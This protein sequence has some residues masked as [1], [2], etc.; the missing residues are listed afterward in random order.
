M[1]AVGNRA[2]EPPRLHLARRRRLSTRSCVARPLRSWLGIAA[3]VGAPL[4]LIGAL[5]WPLLFTDKVFNPD[6]DNHLW[7]MWHQSQAIRANGFPSLYLNYSGAIFYPYYAFYGGTLYAVAG[8]LSLLLGNAPLETYVLSYLL[9]FAAAYGG[10]YWMAHMFGLRGWLVHVPGVIFV[11]SAPYL[12]TIYGF[13]DWPEFLAVSVI[14]LMIAS[15]LSVLRSPQRRIWP[16]VALVG[17]SIMLYGSHAITAIW[18]TTIMLLGVLAMIVCIRDVRHSMTRT[19]VTRVLALIVPALLVNAWFILPA[20]AYESQTVAAASYPHFR[21]LL[22]SSTYVVAAGHLFTLSIAKVP[23]TFVTVALPVLAIVW[24]IGG[25]AALLLMRRGGAWMQALL[26]VAGATALL[27]VL[28]THASLILALPRVYAILQYSL[29][30]DTFVVMGVVGALMIV[31]VLAGQGG[32]NMPRWCWLL[33]PIAILSVVGALRQIDGY[34]NAKN[35]SVALAS[36]LS[37]VY[38]QEG[39]LAYVDDKLPILQTPLAEVDFPSAKV[40][41]NDVAALVHQPPG[42][43]V[44]TNLRAMP[45]LIHISGARIVGTDSQANDVLEIIARPGA[46]T[47]SSVHGPHSSTAGVRIVAGP[48]RNLPVVIGHWLTIFALVFLAAELGLIAVRQNRTGDVD[49]Q[50]TI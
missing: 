49:G 40:P 10:W 20:A 13:A 3:G 22:R 48:A 15:G 23:G 2:N 46:S 50:S 38:E 1:V 25:A 43:R 14:P 24:V 28:M 44:D 36:Y 19:A 18:G 47:P 34:K 31:L 35:R 7:Y 12:T 16:S 32:L 26:L 8:T 5:A 39:L 17:S 4:L 45:H 41:G 6:W 37:P 30:L 27:V 33:A 9:G 29:R 42:R 21:H 11:T